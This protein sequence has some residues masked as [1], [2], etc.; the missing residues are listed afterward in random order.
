MLPTAESALVSGA[1]ISGRAPRCNVF[2]D[3]RHRLSG[4]WSSP[5]ASLTPAIEFIANLALGPSI[6]AGRLPEPIWVSV[7]LPGLPNA[8]SVRSIQ[9]VRSDV[10]GAARSISAIASKCERVGL[11]WPTACTAAMLPA[12]HSG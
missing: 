12:S 9:P 3:E 11:I 7:N 5:I 10:V 1:V 2:I 8:P 6:D 4:T